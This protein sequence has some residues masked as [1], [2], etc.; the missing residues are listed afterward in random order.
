MK[1]N[2]RFILTTLIV[3]LICGAPLVAS[4]QLFDGEREGLLLGVGV[5][6]AAL[7]SG[8]DYEGAA[9]G[10]VASGKI[11][12]GM[13]DQLSLLLSSAVPQFS[14]R[15]GFMYFTDR[16]SDYYLQGLIG[17]AGSEED[18]HLSISGG[19]GYELRDQISVELMLGYTRFSDT[20]TTGINLWTGDVINETSVTNIIT[21]AATFN[22]HFY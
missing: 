4:A 12:Y 20:Y 22:V 5:G 6:F 13:S 7:S 10:F 14:P 16:N 2:L 3:L 15:L 9:S 21:I 19:V 11:G 8:G 1:T 18:R 17:F